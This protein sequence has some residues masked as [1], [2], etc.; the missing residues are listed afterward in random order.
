MPK[1]D[2]THPSPDGSGHLDVVGVLVA[3]LVL[4]GIGVAA[5]VFDRLEPTIGAS[6]VGDDVLALLLLLL[7]GTSFVAIRR[8]RVAREQMEL[9]RDTDERLQALI[10]ESPAVSYSWLPRERRYL[11][12]SPQATTLLGVSVQDHIDDWSAQIHPDDRQRVLEISERA[13]LAGTTYLAEYRIILPDGTER[14]IHDES[15]Y[16]HFDDQGRPTLAQG[17][18]FDITERKEAE[19]RAAAAEERFRTLVERVPAIAYSWDTAHAPG[20]APA[21]YISP[22]IE[23][24]IGVSPRTWL[25]DPAAWATHVHPDDLDRVT[26]AWSATTAAEETFS[27]EYRL[28]TADGRWL[29]VRDEANPVGPGSSGAA[30]YQGVIVDISERHAAEDALRGAEERWRLLL[31]NLPIV[32]YQISFA[33]D[34]TPSERWVASGVEG[35]LGISAAEWL[36]DV[37]TWDRVIHPEDRDAV[38]DA[39]EDMKVTGAPFDLQY[40]MLDRTGV[41]VWVHDRAALTAREGMR[42]VEGAFMNVTARRTAEAALGVAEDRF[43]TLVEQLPAITFIEDVDTGAN[44]YISPQIEAIYGYTTEEWMADPSLWEQRLHPDD[45]DWVIASNDSDGGDEWSVD[46]R[47]ITRD[48][49]TL[50]VHND[51]RLIRDEDGAPLYWQGVVYDITERKGA[52]ERLREAEE[53]YRT[54]VEQLPV[55]IYTDA[56]DDV[57]TAVYISPQYERLTGYSPEQRLMDPDLWVHMLHPDD[58]ESVLAESTRTNETG[59]PFD[60]EYRIIAADG[61]VVW[62]HDHA[63]QVLDPSGNA[64]WHGILQDITE[65]RLAQQTIARRD[66]ILEATSFAA[67][68]F[69][70]TSAW[71]ENL[72]EVLEHLGTAADAT[73]CAVFR[74]H[75]LESGALGVSLAAAWITEGH[76]GEEDAGTW[77]DYAW[78]AEG[79]GRWVE[80]LGAGRPVHGAV[81]GFPERERAVL[82]GG[83]LPIRSL[84]AIPIFAEGQWWGYV[85]FDHADEDRE[86][87]EADIEALGVTASTLG[88]AIDRERAMARLSE[89]QA[90]YRTLIEQLPAVTYIED[91]DTGDETYSSP[92][93]QTLLGY[94]SGEEWGK[95]DQ[96]IAALHADDRD[97][98][99]EQDEECGR[100]GDPFRAEYRLIT[101]GGATVWVRDDATLVRDPDGTPRYWQGVRFDITAEK[102]AEQQLRH[103]EERYRQLVEEMPA[104]TYLDEYEPGRDLWRTRYVSPQIETILGY[105]PEEWL[106]DDPSR[107]R[108]MIHPDDRAAALDA[109]T[110]HYEFGEPLDIEIRVFTKD[111]RLRWLRDQA[112]INRDD[113]GTPRASQGIIQDVTERKLAEL[114]M[115]DAEQRYRAIVEHIP[116]AIY[117]DR[118]DGAMNTVYISPQIAAIAGVTPE[119][120]IQDPALWLSLIDPDDRAQTQDSYQRALAA[121]EPWRAEYRIHTPDGRTVWIHD[122]TTFLLGPEGDPLY[123]QG[124]LF[125][126]T[127]RKLAEQALRESEQR[128]REAAER[129]RALDD[130]KNTFLA[131]VSHELR[132]PLTSILGLSLTLERAPDIAGQDRTDLLA[133]LAANAK[134]LDRL[135]KDLLDIDRLNRGIVEPQYRVTDVSAL[136]R[137]TVEHLDA[138][139]GREVIVQTDPVVIPIDPPK[140]E[141]IVENLLMNAVRHTTGDRTIWLSVAPY[142]GGVRISVEDDGPGVPPDIRAAIFEPFRQGPTQSPHTPGTGIGLSLVARFAELHGGRAWVDEREG[143]GAAFHVV[144]PGRVLE[145]VEIDPARDVASHADAG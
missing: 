135:L 67:E 134:K 95:H 40:R 35:L 98:I 24:L 30:I 1:R 140:I 80:L 15:R 54:L 76:R 145:H 93:T 44:L 139:V 111:G 61:R 100:T 22:Q 129:L 91:I 107:W 113:D 41:V 126:I 79:F 143:G 60:I 66:A 78:E 16:H 136:A 133:R 53:R 73:R 10:A 118:P 92:Q 86:W 4:F 116:A 56:V 124:V 38:L 48:G 82:L 120:W 122:E 52:E 21:D 29:W 97:R 51:A 62:L 5:G 42:V 69:L 77:R 68:Q 18:M 71:Q 8:A 19:A 110:R 75:A 55:A 25:D 20:T 9:R 112:V 6:K 108:T 130:M 138:L 33:A 12:V 104:I 117:L 115:L 45:H 85:S 81:A 74:N 23:R 131:A 89:A 123:L 50:W 127:E 142:D 72:Q 26:R 128:E 102:E 13:D 121:R 137:R 49:R 2:P 47:S 144:I 36:S 28:R 88:A 37:D 17:V 114:A 43:R 141:R 105:A 109:D 83:S 58:R 11:Y 132:S 63:M 94:T 101:K 119:Q 31:E 32:A 103:A 46:Y 65:N 7:L 87:Q 59:E 96:W 106:D 125:D 3:V 64:R 84:V 34:G 99:V 27:Q 57:S 90:L 39:W 70:R 14:W